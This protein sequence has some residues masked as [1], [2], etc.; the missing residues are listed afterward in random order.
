MPFDA[1]SLL[2][3]LRLDTTGFSSGLTSATGQTRN[4]SAS[5]ARSNTTLQ[6]MSGT[7]SGLGKLMLTG[8]GF[9][10]AFKA[11]TAFTGAVG[12]SIDM[13][14]DLEKSMANVSTLIDT[15][16]VDMD[17][18]TESVLNMTS[19]VLKS[20]EDLSA[21]LYQ[22]FSAGITDSAEA[23]EVLRVSAIAA[24]AGL[25]DTLTSV[26][27]ITT[28]IN[29]YGLAAKDAT[30][31]SDLMFQTVKLGKTT[32]EQLAQA[33]GTVIS[34][35]A[36]VGIE[37]DELFAALATLTKG[38]INTMRATTAL[39]A[40]IL[41]VIKPS[42]EA[43]KKAAELGLEWTSAGLKA[44][45]L[46]GFLNDLKEATGGN[47]EVMAELVPNVRALNAVMAL[48]GKQ[49]EEMNRIFAEMAN[50]LGVT[51]E[52]FKKQEDT[53]RSQKVK[54]GL[55][56]DE[57]QTKIGQKFIPALN[58]ML[59]GIIKLFS[60]IG[61][62]LDEMNRKLDPLSARMK[63]LGKSSRLPGQGFDLSTKR[64]N[65]FIDALKTADI[66][67][68]AFLSRPLEEQ[69][70][71]I[72]AIGLPPE[73]T[74]KQFIIPILKVAN[75]K[76]KIAK[77]LTDLEKKR[78]KIAQ[79]ISDDIVRLTEGET[80]LKIVELQRFVDEARI[81]GVNRLQ[82][83]KFI[84][85]NEMALKNKWNQEQIGL[86]NK[87]VQAQ[88][89]L[90]TKQFDVEVKLLNKSKAAW[91]NYYNKLSAQA[92]AHAAKAKA[93]S[94]KV[95]GIEQQKLDMSTRFS[96]FSLNV[97][98]EGLDAEG[99]L[100][101]EREIINQAINR[102]FAAS[103]E[104]RTRLLGDA[105]SKQEGLITGFKDTM[106]EATFAGFNPEPI[107]SVGAELELLGMLVD[108]YNES[109]DVTAEKER[110]I[111]EEQQNLADIAKESMS[112]V[113]T[114]IELVTEEVKKLEDEYKSFVEDAK[115]K[116]KPEVDINPALSSI[117]SLRNAF[118]DMKRTLEKPIIQTVITR[119]KTEGNGEDKFEA[120]RPGVVESETFFAKGG[121]LGGSFQPL[122]RNLMPDNGIFNHPTAGLVNIAEAN[123]PEAVIPLETGA[124]PVKLEG[125]FG[126]QTT[127][128][129][130]RQF[131]A[132][133]N[134]PIPRS[135]RMEKEFEMRRFFNRVSGSNASVSN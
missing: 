2:S 15:T 71:F 90:R 74:P 39:R 83:E 60:T 45:G 129:D 7:A 17:D 77:E 44:K 50:R 101:I 70:R 112:V 89:E 10:V 30:D 18:L 123:N 84:I 122:G 100:S 66:T 72:T 14:A 121:I 67:L 81:V 34:P 49:S 13:A 51:R 79:R 116:I 65:G 135:M 113:R 78:L 134:T 64:V 21:G 38:G 48:T 97:Q 27:A 46:V 131:I 68:S 41:S 9:F 19:E 108:E 43:K 125:D 95:I 12:D 62:E 36:A 63:E 127:S 23:M 124:I 8:L 96:D 6:G 75:I 91:Q 98:K 40:T 106:V 80:A 87:Q 47:S 111:A 126:K 22:V 3:F 110:E 130:Q 73:I 11:V 56:V 132:N 31:I 33:I 94:E 93:A 26:D 69:K 76:K 58:A 25:S 28:V 54:L 119:R 92:Q 82:I 107:I 5:V 99:R 59:K 88:I 42:D 104:E 115:E 118:L 128:S 24:T 109:L 55:L 114:E 53:Y 103:A 105:I 32:Y 4:F 16:T 102:A 29:A 85:A 117:S 52:A 37:L 57:I 1:G 20:S 61:T 86:M 120:T 35:A 133:F